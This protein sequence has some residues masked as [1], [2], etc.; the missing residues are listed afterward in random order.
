MLTA[1]AAALFALSFAPS[2]PAAQ[3][4]GAVAAPEIKIDA[5]SRV[6]I[7]GASVSE[8]F[9]AEQGWQAAFTASIAREFKCVDNGATSL[10]FMDPNQH[11]AT[12]VDAALAA[13]P[14][15][16]LAVDFL[17]W[18]GYG[19]RDADG[20]RIK[21]EEA[22]VA[23]L[24]KGLALLDKFEC[25]VVVGDFP[26]M[27]VSVGKMLQSKQMPATETLVKLNAR[28]AEWAKGKPN[29]IALPLA[30][31][32]NDLH[33]HKTLELAGHKYEPEVTAKWMQDDQLHPT[34]AGLAALAAL[35]DTHLEAHKLI[36]KKDYVA[37]VA[38]V[39]E[40]M[41]PKP[42]KT[43]APVGGK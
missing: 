40:R 28:F 10:F 1:L 3:T 24:E 36:A 41:Q 37:D 23:L 22:R 18:Y 8:G 42:E 43:P 20:G 31:W 6:A 34:A 30:Q 17:F 33:A 15:L 9:Q 7:I 27:S 39:V 2:I 38:K 19:T 4:P 14:T 13:K 12:Q 11:G 35:V 29:V 16:V 26:D 32:M 25:P 21:S 5:L